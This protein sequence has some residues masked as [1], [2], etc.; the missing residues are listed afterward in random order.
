MNVQFGLRAV[1]NSDSKGPARLV[2]AC[3]GFY[4]AWLNGHYIGYGPARTARNYFRVDTWNLD[5]HLQTGLNLL[6]IETVGYNANSYALPAQSSFIIAEATSRSKVLASTNGKGIKFQGIALNERVQKVQRYSWQRHFIEAYHMNRDY[7]SWRSDLDFVARETEL[8]TT[9]DQPVFLPRNAPLPAFDIL[10]PQ[11]IV[12]RGSVLEKSE[13]ETQPWRD[14]SLT[15]IGPHFKGFNIEDLELVVSDDLTKL[16]DAS[17]LYINEKYETSPD[18]CL[19]RGEWAL[20]DF[21]T[22][23]TGFVGI[24]IHCS[25]STRF[26]VLFDEILKPDGKLDFLR[27]TSVNVLTWFLE[28]GDY[29]IETI[30]PYTMRWI[31]ILC[32]EGACKMSSVYMREL[33]CPD[34]NIALFQCSDP[35]LEDIFEAGRETFRQNA[36]DI[37]MDCPSRERAGWLCDSFFTGR[38]EKTLRGKNSIE[39]DFLENFLLP[40]HFHPLPDGMLPMCYPA[41]HPTGNFIPNWPLWLVLELEDYLNRGGDKCIVSA[42]Q[43]KIMDLFRFLNA[44][45]NEDGLLENLPGW[46]FIEWSKANDYTQDVNYPSNMLWAAALEAAGRLYGNDSLRRRASAVRHTVREQS[47]DGEW[48]VDNA[49]RDKTGRLKLTRNRTETCQY[50]A[51]YFGTA[52]PSTYPL[53]WTRLLDSLGPQQ[54]DTLD[55]LHPSNMLVGNCLRLELLSRSGRTAQMRDEIT[56]FFLTMAKTTGTLWENNDTSASCNHAFASHVV[57]WLYKDILGCRICEHEKVVRLRLSESGLKY[58]R[59]VLPLANGTVNVRWR[60]ENNTLSCRVK[61]PPGWNIEP[62]NLTGLKLDLQVEHYPSC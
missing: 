37:L 49:V 5:E 23:Q 55:N 24:H 2:C 13:M 50:Y 28:P 29:M 44:F 30:E 20:L 56:K 54:K 38:V 22:N 14:R 17:S 7:D 32:L 61:V 62:E 40:E 46:V 34:T 21:G 26:H 45:V 1:F 31:K 60:I 25:Q 18:L 19:N 59:A 27:L 58:A 35:E 15:D 16:K 11:T 33:A 8:Q 42:F 53:Q 6:A 12:S 9:K 57:C 43:P 10:R 3:S 51:F 39:R 52:D 47:F 41:D 48:F 4:R 36:V